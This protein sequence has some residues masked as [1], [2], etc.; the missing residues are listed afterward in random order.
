MAGVALVMAVLAILGPLVVGMVKPRCQGAV[1]L[2][3]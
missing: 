1:V 3:G 2:V